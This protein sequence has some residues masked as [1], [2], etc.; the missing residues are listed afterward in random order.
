MSE[1]K[2]MQSETQRKK[3]SC[4]GPDRYFTK[5][6]MIPRLPETF[7]AQNEFISRGS[8]ARNFGLWPTQK[9]P[10]QARK[11]RWYPSYQ[12]DNIFWWEREYLCLKTD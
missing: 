6:R 1:K 7:L 9:I 3:N 11:K 5:T 12:N 2:F 4:K 8:A 10:T